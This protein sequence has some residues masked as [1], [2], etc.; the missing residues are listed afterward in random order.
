MTGKTWIFDLD[1][2]LIPNHHDYS[3]VQLNFLKW[4]EE[5]LY[6]ENDLRSLAQIEF[7][8]WII[9]KIGHKAP[10][11]QSILDLQV[12]MEGLARR[13]MASPEEILSNSFLCT[14]NSIC[15]TLGIFPEQESYEK[16]IE[17][18]EIENYTYSKWDAHSILTKQ[19]EIDS[20][21]A[22]LKGFGKDRFPSSIRKTY[23]VIFED[24]GLNV[25]NDHS[26][27]AY[28]I[29]MGV[30]D[31]DRYEQNGLLPGA[32]K[33]LDFLISKGDRLTLITKGDLEIQEAK[34]EVN[35]LEGWFGDDIFVVNKKNEWIMQRLIS[36][37]LNEED[38]ENMYHV[39]NSIRSDLYPALNSGIRCVYVP[40]ETWA[41][42]RNHN[43]IPE[44]PKLFIFDKIEEIIENY[45][46]L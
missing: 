42:E 25:R 34:I 23:K 39:G 8:Q 10:D 29:G 7:G 37:N 43:G 28:D 36:G 4:I 31:K 1:D 5:K 24:L 6:Y 22:E 20:A 30:F 13:R 2:T 40:C 38:P 41:F 12:R 16:I 9:D 14:Y 21:G 11:I 19:V 26:Q 15:K 3:Y 33:T 17:M 18:G 46:L 44:D 45:D 27:Q 32:A 35:R